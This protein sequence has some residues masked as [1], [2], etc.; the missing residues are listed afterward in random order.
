MN[1]KGLAVDA[2]IEPHQ[3][4]QRR[5]H[6]CG[7]DITF[8]RYVAAEHADRERQLIR[9]LQAARAYVKGYENY[10]A[11]NYVSRRPGSDK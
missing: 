4:Q 2:L 8:Q 9:R 10:T 11:I 6:T 5:R 3:K 7:P 1:H